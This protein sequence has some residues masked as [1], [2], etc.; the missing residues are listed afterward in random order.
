MRLPHGQTVSTPVIAFAELDLPAFEHR[1]RL[2]QPIEQAV[3]V[4]R[5]QADRAAQHVGL[6]HRQMEL[7]HTGIDPH[8]A[9][10]GVEEGIARVAEA[11]DII[12]RRQMLVGDADIDVADADDVADVLRGAVVSWLPWN[13]PSLLK[14]ILKRFPSKWN[15]G[16]V[17]GDLPPPW[18]RV[19]V[20][21]AR[22]CE[23]RSL[24]RPR[25]PH[26]C[27]SPQGGGEIGSLQRHTGVLDDLGPHGALVLDERLG[28]GRAAAAGI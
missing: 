22:R 12:V 16:G 28:L 21:V 15:H 27:P 4:W 3:A 11:G 10:A 26:P 9:R 20:G 23:R 13:G 19:G 14:D 8:V 17:L 25:D 1:F 2:R 7:A 6:T 5:H 24:A 18:G